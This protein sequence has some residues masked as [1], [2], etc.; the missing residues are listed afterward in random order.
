MAENEILYISGARRWRA[1]RRALTAGDDIDSVADCFVDDLIRGLRNSLVVSLRKGATLLALLRAADVGR[2]ALSAVVANFQDK[3]LARIVQRA[4]AER[5]SHDG[6]GIARYVGQIIRDAV[7]ER[8]LVY[9]GRCD[10]YKTPQARDAL[11]QRL[12]ARLKLCEP[13]LTSLLQSSARGEAVRRAARLR[14]TSQRR[15]ASAVVS[16]SLLGRTGG[17]ADVTRRR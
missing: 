17:Q 9:A 6:D 14:A 10:N 1:T 2:E 8:A 13:E 5:G 15:P 16:T 7:L 12:S 11:A 4:I 3:Q